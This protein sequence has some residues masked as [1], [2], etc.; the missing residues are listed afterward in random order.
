MAVSRRGGGWLSLGLH[1]A[2]QIHSHQTHGQGLA[3]VPPSSSAPLLRFSSRRPR[4]SQLS[5]KTGAGTLLCC[6]STLLLG[7]ILWQA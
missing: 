4:R 7:W 6:C 1:Q 2:E 5:P 3:G